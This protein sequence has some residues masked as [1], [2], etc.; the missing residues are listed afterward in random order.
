MSD[1]PR[2]LSSLALSA[3]MSH[4][5]VQSPAEAELPV[6][7]NQESR[8]Y[9]R[10]NREQTEKVFAKILLHLLAQLK[11]T[12]FQLRSATEDIERE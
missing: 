3:V 7:V 2:P 11:T 12:Q 5:K 1:K 9:L 10:A 4:L 6:R 8:E